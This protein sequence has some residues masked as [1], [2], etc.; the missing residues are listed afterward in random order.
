METGH[1]PMPN[2]IPPLNEAKV[3]VL[4]EIMAVGLANLPPARDK[5]AIMGPYK[6][7]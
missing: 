1:T 2:A 5:N 3:H 7:A 6:N 4:Q